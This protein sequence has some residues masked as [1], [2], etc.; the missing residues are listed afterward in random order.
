[1]MKAVSSSEGYGNEKDRTG[2]IVGAVFGVSM[3]LRVRSRNIKVN[4]AKALSSPHNESPSE[5]GGSRRRG[6]Q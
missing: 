5:S 3:H 1:M 6:G 4:E 2:S